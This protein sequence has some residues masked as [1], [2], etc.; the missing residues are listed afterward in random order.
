MIDFI[1]LDMNIVCMHIVC[2]EMKFVH[3]NENGVE[4]W[5]MG[6]RSL[7]LMIC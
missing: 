5:I 3:V 6:V 2:P 7:V 4:K 1:D